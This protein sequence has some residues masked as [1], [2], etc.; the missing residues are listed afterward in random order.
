MIQSNGGFALGTYTGTT[1]TK[2]FT[3]NEDGYLVLALSRKVPYETSEVGLATPTGFTKLSES[4]FTYGDDSAAQGLYIK[5]CTSGEEITIT[6]PHDTRVD[7]STLVVPENTG[8]QLQY[9]E[10]IRYRDNG[11]VFS[12]IT[13]PYNADAIYGVEIEYKPEYYYEGDARYPSI[14][15]GWID[16]FT[17]GHYY[18]YR[19]IYLRYRGT[20]I[21]ANAG[22]VLTSG[23]N[24]IS[25][26]D[27]KFTVNGSVLGTVD[28]SQPLGVYTAPL[29]IFNK[30]ETNGPDFVHS[31]NGQIRKVKIYGQGG[32]LLSTWYPF[33]KTYSETG[34]LK[35]GMY[36]SEYGYALAK[37]VQSNIDY[38]Y[39][40]SGGMEPGPQ[41]NYGINGDI[42]GVYVTGADSYSYDASTNNQKIFEKNGTY[43][44]VYIASSINIP[45]S[46]D[47]TQSAYSSRYIVNEI[48]LSTNEIEGGR[49]GLLGGFSPAKSSGVTFVCGDNEWY[50]PRPCVTYEVKFIDADT[51]INKPKLGTIIRNGIHYAPEASKVIPTYNGTFINDFRVEGVY[52]GYN[53]NVIKYLIPSGVSN[54]EG[55]GSMTYLEVGNTTVAF[56]NAWNIDLTNPVYSVLDSWHNVILG[57]K[58]IP[59]RYFN[60]YY[61]S[62]MEWNDNDHVY[63]YGNVILGEDNILTSSDYDS[64]YYNVI[65]GSKNISQS[66]GSSHANWI[67]GNGNN[68]KNYGNMSVFC[69]GSGNNFDKGSSFSYPSTILGGGNKVYASSSPYSS[70]IFIGG[71]NNK[72]AAFQNSQTILGGQNKVEDLNRYSI[73]YVL[74]GTTHTETNLRDDFGRYGLLVTGQSNKIY[75]GAVLC[76]G[77]YNRI[78]DDLGFNSN[79][80]FSKYLNNTNFSSRCVIGQ[81]NTIAGTMLTIGRYNEVNNAALAIIGEHNHCN[82][83]SDVAY[84]Y[85]SLP[86]TGSDNYYLFRKS[87]IFGSGNQSENSGSIL[88]FLNNA[89]STNIIVGDSNTTS[90]ANTVIGKSN[91]VTNSSSSQGNVFGDSNNV[92]GNTGDVF[93]SNNTVSSGGC[94]VY[95][96][97][98]T[99]NGGSYCVGFGNT[100][101]NGSTVFG[102]SNNVTGG[103]SWKVIGFNNA[104]QGG[105][106]PVIGNGNTFNSGNMTY[107]ILGYNNTVESGGAAFGCGNNSIGG[108]VVIGHGNTANSGSTIIGTSNRITGGGGHYIVGISNEAN[109]TSAQIIGFSNTISAGLAIG[110][111]LSNTDTNGSRITIGAYNNASVDIGTRVV[112]GDGTGTSDRHNLFI[113]DYNHNTYFSGNIYG[114]NL[115]DAP[116]T[117]GTYTLQCVV[118]VVDDTVTKT[119]SWI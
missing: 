12:Y 52:Q 85:S 45:L 36:S 81:S 27:N 37:E 92:S 116:N 66:Q 7:V 74:G 117:A 48:D 97:G 44:A 101:I 50:D 35:Y 39:S 43:G 119:Y 21:Y 82:M 99:V 15:S 9:L 5:Q 91:T 63:T 42:L 78:N 98:N 114:T 69:A 111:Y 56:S 118:T 53:K 26:K 22:N 76:A 40:Y 46:K 94:H 90:Y 87:L 86:W 30:A 95:G 113:S 18:Q 2:T 19:G 3:P 106:G 25:V 110:K 17:I 112:F 93:G 71:S 96:N 20:E 83:T 103:G 49:C 109:T 1:I 89:T 64:F 108:S 14:F 88:G 24:T 60:N 84:C 28:S 104:L 41:L 4:V 10:N 68:I 105:G 102:S 75:G 115:P 72:L 31:A 47:G 80:N 33:E 57:G 13:L 107:G 11:E 67:I 55:S 8:T 58:I 16:D 32:T 77:Y 70:Q 29:T 34:Y 73:S 62:S 6:L 61:K 54:Y 100:A 38:D 51:V 59:R 23:W 79:A 65:L